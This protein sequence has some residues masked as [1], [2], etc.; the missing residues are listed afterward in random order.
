MANTAEGEVSTYYTFPIMVKSDA[1]FTRRQICE[2]LE[3]K[4][5]ETRSM[6]GGCLPDQPGFSN[7]NHRVVGSL[8]YAREVRDQVFFVGCHPGLSDS[9][10]AYMLD[11][12]DDFLSIH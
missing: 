3:E 12:F 1:P 2:Y 8:E 10:V 11:C 5:I 9:D 7:R 6:M 4:N